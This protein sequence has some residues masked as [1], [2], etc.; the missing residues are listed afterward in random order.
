M[1]KVKLMMMTL[2][3]SLIFIPFTGIGQL[4]VSETSKTTIGEIKI[5]NKFSMSV[6]EV[7]GHFLFLFRNMKYSSIL[8]LE[9]FELNSKKEMDQLYDIIIKHINTDEKK[10]LDI[11]L[12]NKDVLTLTFKN[13]KVSFN[14]WD[15]YSLHYSAYYTEE[16]I[17]QLFGK[18]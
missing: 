5:V 10:D 8:S 16:N 1:K 14:V 9:G 11:K 13:N 7:E 17:N 6:T 4:E 15:G 18:K 12:K 3:M 2:I